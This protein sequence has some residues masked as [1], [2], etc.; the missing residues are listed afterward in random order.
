MLSLV[1]W[2][3]SVHQRVKLK[4]IFVSINFTEIHSFLYQCVT[5]NTFISQQ[6]AIVTYVKIITLQYQTKLKSLLTLKNILL[7]KPTKIYNETNIHA[8][9]CI[10]YLKANIIYYSTGVS[11]GPNNASN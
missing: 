4:N 3:F 10:I 5:S 1:T 6:L 8:I 7:M 2:S 11:L 9:K